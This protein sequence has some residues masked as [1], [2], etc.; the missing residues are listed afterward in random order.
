MRRILAAH[1]TSP[2]PVGY[3][4]ATIG[5]D[6]NCKFLRGGS[7]DCVPDI[8][9]RLPDGSLVDVDHDGRVRKESRH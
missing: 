2:F 9:L 7:C 8:T 4:R 5:H 1:A 3:S 6:R